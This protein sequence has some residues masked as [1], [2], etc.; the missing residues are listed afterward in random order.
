MK[1]KALLIY[2]R[3]RYS[4]QWFTTID[5]YEDTEIFILR[6]LITIAAVIFSGTL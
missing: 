2:L 3:R 5:T 4:L 1:I 6:L